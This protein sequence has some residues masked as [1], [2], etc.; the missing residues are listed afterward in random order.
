MFHVCRDVP[1]N[2]FVI[3]VDVFLWSFGS[4]LIF[5]E[6]FHGT[7]LPLPPLFLWLFG[8]VCNY[9]W[10]RSMERLYRGCA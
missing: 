5:V 1:W 2:V 10:R 4:G 8:V 6:T 9:Y 3:V 7:S